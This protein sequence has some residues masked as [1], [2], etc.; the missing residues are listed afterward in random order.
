MVQNMDYDNIPCFKCQNITEGCNEGY[1]CDKCGSIA[2]LCHAC[3]EPM[4]LLN[5]YWGWRDQNQYDS[6][7]AVYPADNVGKEFIASKDEE[8][9][10][11][12]EQAQF[13]WKCDKC[14]F[15]EITDCD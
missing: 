13:Y 3:H 8:G 1:S 6:F 9:N 7:S 10:F 12:Y 2:N 14:K 15:E 11:Y 5:F 4:K